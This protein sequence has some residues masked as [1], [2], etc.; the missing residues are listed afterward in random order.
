MTSR[1]PYSPPSPPLHADA[2][3]Q[4]IELKFRNYTLYTDNPRD[5]LDLDLLKENTLRESDALDIANSRMSGIVMGVERNRYFIRIELASLDLA[6]RM[7]II[8]E[9][10]N[11]SLELYDCVEKHLA[12]GDRIIVTIANVYR[13]NHQV[14]SDAVLCELVAPNLIDWDD[15]GAFEERCLSE[16]AQ[17]RAM[18]HRTAVLG[19]GCRYFFP[20][21]EPLNLT[22]D[23][24]YVPVNYPNTRLMNAVRMSGRPAFAI[25]TIPATDELPGE[26]VYDIVMLSS[27][28]ADEDNDL[29][30]SPQNLVFYALK[31]L[32]DDLCGG[33][34]LPSIING[35]NGCQIDLTNIPLPIRFYDLILRETELDFRTYAT[36]EEALEAV[37]A[38]GLLLPNDG[39]TY[40]SVVEV[41]VAV[42]RHIVFPSLIQPEWVVH[43]PAYEY[44]FAHHYGTEPEDETNASEIYINGKLIASYYGIETNP[45]LVDFRQLAPIYYDADELKAIVYAG[46]EPMTRMQI[47]IDNVLALFKPGIY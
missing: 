23:S 39:R 36:V 42:A 13:D 15:A 30:V 27:A 46:L 7:W 38:A 16:A 3:L 31:H 8:F 41:A 40:H 18:S 4:K 20:Q 14:T 17:V 34:I 43:F 37:A 9:P 10:A 6:A 11:F 21:Q 29:E 19:V 47:F 26:Q 22:D 28:I 33:F 35:P 44:G 25:S 32:G 45:R 1:S 5:T 2:R 24:P 12:L